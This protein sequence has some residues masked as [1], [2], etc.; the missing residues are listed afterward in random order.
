VK[1][2]RTIQK[3]NGIVTFVTEGL[4]INNLQEGSGDS[5][6]ELNESLRPQQVHQRPSTSSAAPGQ[7]NRLMTHNTHQVQK[8]AET[9]PT[10]R[11]FKVFD[12]HR[13]STALGVVSKDKNLNITKLLQSQN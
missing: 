3:I 13:N 2:R 5:S 9:S 11:E 10:E 4:K 12:L 6:L 8:N 1:Q 7:R